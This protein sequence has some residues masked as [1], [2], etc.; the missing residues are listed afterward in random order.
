MV[1][2]RQNHLSQ[3]GL[4]DKVANI[5]GN[6]TLFDAGSKGNLLQM[7]KWAKVVNDAWVLGGVHRQALFRLASP[8]AMHN[9]W[10]SSGGYFI[11][12]A[13]EIAG[14]LHFGYEYQRIGPWQTLSSK[15]YV[16]ATTADLVKYDRH[17]RRVESIQTA[18]R[19]LVL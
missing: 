1:I 12:T 5:I 14:L 17:V 4:F 13:R 16:K 11:V 2:G 15:N 19:L 18:R 9:L 8:L 10:N 6:N 7:D 3:A